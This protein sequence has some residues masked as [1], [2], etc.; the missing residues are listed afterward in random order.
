MSL[1]IPIQLTIKDTEILARDIFSRNVTHVLS[2]QHQVSL[3]FF[4]SNN[5]SLHCMP[6]SQH[7]ELIVSINGFKID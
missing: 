5:K 6:V 1:L 3:F 4:F 2:S 7:L